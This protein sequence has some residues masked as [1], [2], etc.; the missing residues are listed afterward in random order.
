MK[1]RLRKLLSGFLCFALIASAFVGALCVSV[2]PVKAADP[3]TGYFNDL[4]E[5]ARNSVPAASLTQFDNVVQQIHDNFDSWLVVV[6]YKPTDG[7]WYVASYCQDTSKELNYWGWRNT[8]YYYFFPTYKN[9]NTNSHSFS[10]RYGFKIKGN[11]IWFEPY[12]TA[13]GNQTFKSDAFWQDSWSWSAPTPDDVNESSR[14]CYTNIDLHAYNGTSE[15]VFLYENLVNG[16]YVPPII[17]FHWFKF[18]LGQRWYVT[19]YDQSL[20]AN[21]ETGDDTFWLWSFYKYLYS[22]EEPVT[23]NVE[24]SDLQYLPAAAQFIEQT[25]TNLSPNGILAY[26]ITNLVLSGD[27]IQFALSEFYQVLD[28]PGGMILGNVMASSDDIISLVLTP[29]EEN[30]S[31]NN[32]WNEIAEYNENYPSVT[33]SPQE[34]AEQ[35]LGS[36]AYTGSMGVIQIPSGIYDWCVRNRPNDI[37]HGDFSADGY[38]HYKL[39]SSGIL[40]TNLSMIN[41]SLCNAC[42]I[43]APDPSWIT[44]YIGIDSYSFPVYWWKPSDQ[45][46]SD[47][48]FLGNFTIDMILQQ[49]DIVIFAPSDAPYLSNFDGIFNFTGS[50]GF[51]NLELDSQIGAVNCATRHQVFICSTDKVLLKSQLFAFCDSSSKMYDLLS[52]YID[53]R[54]KWDD[55]F[56]KWS[57]SIFWELETV[58]GHLLSI[59]TEIL[60]WDLGTKLSSIVSKLQEISDNTSETDVDPWYLALFNWIKAFEPSNIDFI[61]WVEEYDDFVDDLPDPGGATIIPF[62]TAAPT[63]LPTVAVAGG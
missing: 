32:A 33:I 3:V 60:S 21:L 35:V 12:D 27:V 42:I 30:E 45:V 25:V 6:I 37:E 50:I 54:D 13:L 53:K 59:E 26:D 18:Q 63:A 10:S 39:D 40:S 52:Q 56:F 49:F 8:Y 20:L 24:W 44:D 34:L 11:S 58:N 28:T 48:S 15:P 38:W 47:A 41:W 23:V 31:Q 55:S 46:I 29:E 14:R 4:M 16:S 51:T 17:D 19:T 2:L 61:G 7:S 62:P 5:Q 36:R 1:Q 43:P 22:Q 57:L 9:D